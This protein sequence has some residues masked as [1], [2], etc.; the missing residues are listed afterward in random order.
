M[1]PFVNNTNNTNDKNAAR[2]IVVF[3]TMVDD[4]CKPQ[5]SSSTSNIT[6]DHHH[7]QQHQYFAHSQASPSS[8]SASASASASSWT[9]NIKKFFETGRA[10]ES[11]DDALSWCE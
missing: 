7:Q 3:D 11:D 10:L 5:A 2:H 6:G 4:K 1:N 9:T 8:A